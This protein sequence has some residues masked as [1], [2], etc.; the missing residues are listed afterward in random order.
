MQ[1]CPD[2]HKKVNT[3]YLYTDSNGRRLQCPSCSHTWT[4]KETTN[5]DESL[6]HKGT[7]RQQRRCG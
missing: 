5:E 3:I 7:R 1:T 2:C 6:C 4:E